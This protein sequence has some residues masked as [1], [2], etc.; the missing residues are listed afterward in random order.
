MSKIIRFVNDCIED[1]FLFNGGDFGRHY[2]IPGL[3]F[4]HHKIER[5]ICAHK[6]KVSGNK[7]TTIIEAPAG[8]TP[9][10]KQIDQCPVGEFLPFKT[11]FCNSL[12]PEGGE[13]E[14]ELALGIR[15]A[16]EGEFE[17]KNRQ[18]Y[19]VVIDPVDVFNM[20]FGLGK[21][22][23]VHHQ[24]NSL[25]DVVNSHMNLVP[26]LNV[27]VVEDLTPIIGLVVHETV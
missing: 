6:E 19:K 4:S 25:I 3:F 15:N 11:V 2:S 10:L 26:Y 22:S 8:F 18:V 23:I 20:P 1:L 17:T 16:L 24:A 5:Y 13:I 14:Y 21:V 27:E 7:L 12:L 9:G